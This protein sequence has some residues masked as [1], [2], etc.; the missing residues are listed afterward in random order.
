MIRILELTL[1]MVKRIWGDRQH[2]CMWSIKR[3]AKTKNMY[4]K[5]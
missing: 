5:A 1:K 2:L 3:D 4:F